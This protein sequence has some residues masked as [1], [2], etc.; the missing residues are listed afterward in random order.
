MGILSSTRWTDRGG[1]SGLV[2]FEVLRVAGLALFFELSEL[3]CEGAGEVG[4]DR[5][6]LGNDKDFSHLRRGL[7]DES[8]R[9]P[10]VF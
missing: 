5:G 8:G 2:V 3:G 4:C 10:R 1:D 6:F 9:L 7:T